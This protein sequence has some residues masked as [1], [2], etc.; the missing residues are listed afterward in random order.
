MSGEPII[1][2]GSA[3]MRPR[4]RLISLIGEELI[5]DEA[6]A[7]VELVKNAYDADATKVA[8]SHGTTLSLI[9]LRKKN[10]WDPE[11]DFENLRNRLSR[12][13]SPFGDVQ[14]FSI[15]LVIPGFPELTGEVQPHELIRKP[16]YK[17]EGMLNSDGM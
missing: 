5:S 13:I 11:E 7:V 4:A 2:A 8:I 3:K 14:D 9:G 16:T 6:V 12:L 1:S 15:E 17:L 10:D